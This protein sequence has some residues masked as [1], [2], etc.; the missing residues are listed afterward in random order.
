MQDAYFDSWNVFPGLILYLK[1]LTKFKENI[2][3]IKIVADS[4]FFILTLNLSI[5]ISIVLSYKA[6]L[7]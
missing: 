6:F 2:N 3:N 4:P 5:Y 7:T 1:V